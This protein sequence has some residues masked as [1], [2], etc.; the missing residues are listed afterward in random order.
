MK[1]KLALFGLIA[2]LSMGASLF[3]QDT[4]FTYQGQVTDNGTKFTGVGQFKFALVTSTNYNHQATATANPPSGG[5]ITLINVTSGGSGYASTPAVTITGGGGSGATATASPPSGGVVTGITVN[6]PGSGYTSSPTV[7]VAPPPP[8]IAYATFW[9]NDGTG[10]GS[11]STQPTSAVSV[12][13]TNGLFTVTLGDT[14]LANMTAIGASLFTQPNLQLRIWFNDSVNGFAA[15]SPVQNLTPAPYA[16]FANSAGIAASATNATTA[17]SATTANNFSGSLS[18]DVTGTQVATVVASVGGQSAGN[19]AGAVST[20]YS[21]TSADT[22]YSI[23]QRDANGSFIA[24]SI[25]LANNLNLPTTTTSAGTINSGGSPFIHNYGTRNIFAGIASG[26]FTTSGNDNAGFG[27]YVLN[28]VTSGQQNVGLGSQALNQFKS[29]NGNTAIGFEALGNFTSGQ[30]NIALGFG[31][32]GSITTGNNNIYIGNVGSSGDSGIMRIGTQGSQVSTFIAGIYNDSAAT[33]VPVYVTSSGQLGTLTSSAKFK[34]HIQ[35]MGDASDVL[36]ALKPVTYQYKPEI[37]PEG[38][39]QFGLVAEDVE[40]V[41]PDLVVHD[42]EHG[43]YTV[44]Y[45]AVDAML[46]NEFLKEHRKVESQSNQIE[47]LQETVEQLKDLVNKLA[48][49]QKTTDQK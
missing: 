25:A 48:A 10:I 9:S 19:V 30:N 38:T 3:A 2:A 20:V 17:T 41:N 35:S 18:G 13:V 15:L 29:G 37:D 49:T 23:V 24:G 28:A 7:T 16:D 8:N 6:N 46:L 12:G 32:G 45:Q 39:P 42:A 47:Q 44:R 21:A 26:N 31:A 40:K 14:T 27:Y 11:G 1:T 36:L 33:G 22:A 34:E 43:I 4:V 5:F